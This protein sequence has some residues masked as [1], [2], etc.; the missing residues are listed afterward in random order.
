MVVRNLRQ[1]SP[2]VKPGLSGRLC[3]IWDTTLNRQRVCRKSGFS[4]LKLAECQVYIDVCIIY[5]SVSPGPPTA[6]QLAGSGRA[7]TSTNSWHRQTCTERAHQ[8]SNWSN[9]GLLL[10]K[11]RSV[12]DAGLTI[13]QHC[14]NVSSLLGSGVEP[15]LSLNRYCCGDSC[16]ARGVPMEATGVNIDMFRTFSSTLSARGPCLHVRFWRVNRSPR[17]KN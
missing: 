1:Q 11:R 10:V 14:F 3:W 8:T 15:V 2:K 7:G 16:M 13:N 17:W 9:A 6:C 12:C 5:R 4:D